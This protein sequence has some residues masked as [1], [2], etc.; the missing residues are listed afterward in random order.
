MVAVLEVFRHFIKYDGSIFLHPN[1][2]IYSLLHIICI[3]ISLLKIKTL[4]NL[5]KNIFMGLVP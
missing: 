2:M 5:A 1:F 4:R 3:F